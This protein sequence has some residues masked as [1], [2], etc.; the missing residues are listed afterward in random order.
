[1]KKLKIALLLLAFAMVSVTAQGAKENA[2]Q[3]EVQNTRVFVDSLGR[4]STLPIE[5]ERVAPSGN[6]AQ[7]AVYSMNPQIMVGWGTRPTEKLY[8][9]FDKDVLE[10]PVFGAFY[11]AKANLNKEAVIVADPQVIVDVGEI[12][13]SKEEMI[14]ELDSLQDDLGIPV[15]FIAAYL[16]DMGTTFRAL[17][18]LF[19][20]EEEG[21]IKAQYSEKT[22]ERANAATASIK[23]EDEVTVYFGVGSDGLV[24]YPKGSFRTQTLRLAGLDNVVKAKGKN[25]IVSPEQL[26]IWNPDIIILSHDGG[27]EEFM[28]PSSPFSELTAVKTGNVYLVPEGPF[29]WVDTPPS[30]NRLLGINW[31]GNLIY[32]TYFDFD[33][34]AEA[35][36]FY[37]IFYQTELNDSSLDELL[38]GST[39]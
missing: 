28:D 24:S 3:N 35:K 33:M 38:K 18:E 11:G 2:V 7:I 16:D 13:G 34:R 22:I 37:K 17:G 29:S 27:Y 8:K 31:L 25:V 20:L 39:K 15:V 19:N 23:E 9:Y 30:L 21:E 6:M 26:L 36:T 14:K 5:V 1:M 12:K 32:P 4:T 10:R